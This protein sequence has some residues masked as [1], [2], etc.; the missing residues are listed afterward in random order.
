MA[1]SRLEQVADHV[2]W[3]TPD[4]RSDRPSLVA[5]LG[6][7]QTAVVD[8]GASAAHARAFLDALAPLEPAPLRAVAL[9]HWHWDHSFGAGAY[10]APVV[11]QRET[12]AEVARQASLAWDETSL[13]ERVRTGAEL[14]FCADMLHVEY[15]GLAGIEIALPHEV[16]DAELTLELG[17]VTCRLVHVG[18]DHAADSVVAHIPEDGVLVLG[19]CHYPRLYASREHYTPDGLRSVLVRL[20]GFTPVRHVIEGHGEEALDAVGFASQLARLEGAID[21]VEELG[22]EAIGTATSDDDRETLELLL[23]GFQA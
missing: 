7:R 4:E 10:D 16:F 18:G 21:R 17:G 20:R 6:E 1:D 3:F 23:A 5:V 11:A 8:A 19:D 2:W 14:E 22:E 13:A 12:A 15:P 9:T